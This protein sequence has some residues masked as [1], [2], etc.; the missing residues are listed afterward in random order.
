MVLAIRFVQL[1]RDGV[2]NDQVELAKLA[3]HSHST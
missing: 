2:V 1:L 3:A